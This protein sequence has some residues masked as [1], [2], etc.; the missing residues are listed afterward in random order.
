M[1]DAILEKYPKDEV[2]TLI[3]DMID[4]GYSFKESV[5]ILKNVL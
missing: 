2:K 3:F 5:E 1:L 4:Y